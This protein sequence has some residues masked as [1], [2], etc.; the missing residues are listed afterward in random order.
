M[1]HMLNVEDTEVLFTVKMR[2]LN[3]KIVQKTAVFS[4]ILVIRNYKTEFLE[5]KYFLA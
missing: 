1:L 4:P 3:L 2:I 5:R